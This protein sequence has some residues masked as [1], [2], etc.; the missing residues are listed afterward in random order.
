M[1]ELVRTDVLYKRVATEGLSSVEERMKG[2]VDERKTLTS[3]ATKRTS[4]VE[5]I[6]I[7]ITAVALISAVISTGLIN[8]VIKIVIATLGA[9]ATSL[10]YS[11]KTNTTKIL[12]ESEREAI[13]LLKD[14]QTSLYRI[15]NDFGDWER[16]QFLRTAS[17][18]P[19]SLKTLEEV[20]TELQ[21]L[22]KQLEN[23]IP[24]MVFPTTLNDEDIDNCKDLL[25]EFATK[26]PGLYN[27]V[28]ERIETLRR[29]V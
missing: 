17:E 13:S 20:D 11:A 6:G 10:S 21:P 26:Q 18:C 9:L 22:R 1:E 8:I 23:L 24:N 3:Q 25:T 7:L 15:I 16:S 12:S 2:K 5:G 29:P 14:R 27:L 4:W 19:I 28:Q